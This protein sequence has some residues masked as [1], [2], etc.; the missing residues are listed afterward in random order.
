MLLSRLHL[1]E[2]IIK[3]HMSITSSK[4][5]VDENYR[6]KVKEKQNALR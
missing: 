4:F 3:L 1:T 5:L 6:V 2:D